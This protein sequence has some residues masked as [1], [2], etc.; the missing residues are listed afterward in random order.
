MFYPLSFV[1]FYFLITPGEIA[2]GYVHTVANNYGVC[3]VVVVVVYGNKDLV[4][5][6][7][8]FVFYRFLTPE[9]R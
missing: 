3:A 4:F 7:I 6:L 5:I 1:G 2:N 9:P 8:S